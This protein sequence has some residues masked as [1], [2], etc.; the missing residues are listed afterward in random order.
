[1]RSLH[2]L[3]FLFAFGT[4]IVCHA[5]CQSVDVARKDSRKVCNIMDFGA[6]EGTR[7]QGADVG[8]AIMRAYTQCVQKSNG[9]ATLLIPAGKSFRLMSRVLFDKGRNLVVQWDG[10]IHLALMFRVN[11]FNLNGAMIQFMHCE[12]VKLLG[13]GTFFGYGVLYRQQ[14]KVGNDVPLEKRPRMIMFYK[15]NHVE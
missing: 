8:P 5:A 4:L 7:D 11:G 9:S 13:K 12:G 10:N 2:Y 1:M 15:A 3:L 14:A 6:T